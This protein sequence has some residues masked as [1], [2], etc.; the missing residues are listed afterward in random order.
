[1]LSSALCL[2]AS[3]IDHLFDE[4]L[5]LFSPPAP[6][7]VCDLD[8][9]VKILLTPRRA[10]DDGEGELPLPEVE[11]LAAEPPRFSPEDERFVTMFLEEI[12][13]P[14]QRLSHMLELAARRGMSADLQT[15]VALE[16][17]RAYGE[18]PTSEALTVEPAGNLFDH[19]ICHGDDLILTKS[20]GAEVARG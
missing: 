8:A 10:E 16:M 13:A 11:E 9:L 15:L 4:L 3:T 20:E 1:M 17:L 12:G 19:A 18:L 6:Q 14:G 5:R 7:P 2:R